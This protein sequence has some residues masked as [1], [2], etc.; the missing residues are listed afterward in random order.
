M[1]HFKNMCEAQILEQI[2]DEKF[3]S[4]VSVEEVGEGRGGGGW[5]KE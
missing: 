2:M 5:W 1:Y 4:D 3:T